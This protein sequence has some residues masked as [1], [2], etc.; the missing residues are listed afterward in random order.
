VTAELK[1]RTKL[2]ALKVI[3]LVS[4]FPR[5]KCADIIGRQLI[6]SATSVGANYRA[7]CRGQTR[8]QFIAKMNIAL[9]ESDESEYWL[10]LSEQ[11]EY[12]DRDL[13]KSVLCET[14][15]LTAIFIASIKTAGKK[16][17]TSQRS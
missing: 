13:L 4:T 1:E 11:L 12:G 10:E 7:A 5:N 15:E 17:G 3:H 14:H 6:K 9:E 2:F 16:I 8:A